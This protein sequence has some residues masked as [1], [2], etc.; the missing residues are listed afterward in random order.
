VGQPGPNAPT[1]TEYGTGSTYGNGTSEEH[2]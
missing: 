1:G 2:R